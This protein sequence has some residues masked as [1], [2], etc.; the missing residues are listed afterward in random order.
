MA[1]DG[2]VLVR[3]GHTEAAVD[4]ARLAGLNPSGVICEIMNDDGTHGPAAGPGGLRPAARAQGRHHRRPDRLPPHATTGWSSARS[5]PTSTAASAAISG[6]RSMPT[7]LTGSSTWRWS[8]ATSPRAEPVLVRV[9]ARQHAGGPAGRRRERPRR[10]AAPGDGDDRRGRPRRRRAAARA[11]PRRHLSQRI[12]SASA[13]SP[14]AARPA[15]LRHRRPDPDRPRR[16]RHDPAV[17]QRQDHRRPRRLRPR[18]VETRP[19]IL[20]GDR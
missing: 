5:P 6:C 17:Q 14:Q 16:A 3:A 2:G 18:V 4:I 15:R 20:P 9:H 19:I 7:C 10:P 1:R 13:T 11:R 12:R 8:R